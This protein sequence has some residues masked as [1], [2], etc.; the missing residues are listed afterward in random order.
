MR[1]LSNFERLVRLTRPW[2]SCF[3]IFL[4][5]FTA[6]SVGCDGDRRE[7][8]REARIARREAKRTNVEQTQTLKGANVGDLTPSDLLRSAVDAYKSAKYYSDAGYVEIL[9][10]FEGSRALRSYRTP[11]SLSFAKPNYARME[12][13]S[14]LLRSDGRTIRAEIRES[15]YENQILERPAPF[16]TTSIKEFY[17]DARFAEAASLG[18]PTNIFWTSPQLILLLA[19]DP[20]KTLAP[21][22]AKL[23]LLEPEFARLE[24][25]DAVLCDRVK[26]EAEDGT[27]V[28][29]FERASRR[30]TRCDLPVE[31]QEVPDSLA[32]VVSLR[33]EF[34]RQ[35]LSDK[36]PLELSQYQFPKNDVLSRRIVERF[37]PP[38]A[39][40]TERA[41]TD[42]DSS[43]LN[44]RF[45]KNARL[46]SDFI[47]AASTNDLYRF[48]PTND[49]SREIPP[50]RFPKKLSL[51][52]RWSFDDLHAPVN[53]LAVS[54][55]ECALDKQALSQNERLE[56]DFLPIASQEQ[57]FGDMLIVPCDG[58]ALALLSSDGRLIRKT[59]TSVGASEPITFVRTTK[60]GANRRYYVASA[61]LQSRMARR[62]DEN[63]NDLGA[64][65]LGANGGRR[66]GDARFV[67]LDEDDEPELVLGAVEDA[68]LNVGSSSCVYAV[69]T[70]SRK[71]RWKREEY[72][73]PY[74]FAVE[75]SRAFWTVERSSEGADALVCVD[76]TSG[77]RTIETR[78]EDGETFLWLATSDNLPQ[79]AARVVAIV[80]RAETN[81]TFL[82]GYD[83]EGREMWRRPVDAYDSN[84]PLEP[85]VS[86]DVDG[87][88][89]D[90]WLAASPNGSIR[91]F[92]SDGTE[93]DVFQYG[94]E[95]SG[96]CV[97]RW[98]G[99]SFLVLTD[100]SRVVVWKIEA[101]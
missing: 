100:A 48:A 32:R 34:P 47:D 23:S 5:L 17:P 20:I 41:L 88:G 89:C 68:S 56:E 93:F 60:V 27:R 13:G 70:K 82:V 38:E 67:D 6:C 91:F 72:F 61:R 46:F 25:E 80:E 101:I 36:A 69:E 54:S 52:E 62:F 7:K 28:Y 4:F 12:F 78:A 90:E 29:W 39:L 76:L 64:L 19:Q 10:E 16:L 98:N 96:V 49:S 97:A 21:E 42:G 40:M 45:H 50:R 35:S 83:R 43:E 87:D 92:K 14:A 51:R 53:P 66:V 58:A 30:L 11:C 86:G 9:C 73:E 33:L 71:I 63:F 85:V 79:D 55:Q 99:D 44:E 26:V 8:R 2:T 31:R 59:T 24:D 95:I 94:R 15:D 84:T 37:L 74:V 77:E 75:S 1:K 57:T 65:D 81:E 3:L 22:G 18:T